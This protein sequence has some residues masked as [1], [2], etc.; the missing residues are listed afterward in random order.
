MTKLIDPVQNFVQSRKKI[1]DYFDCAGDYYI[2]PLVGQEWLI[3]KVDDFY[4]LTYWTNEDVKMDAVVVSKGGNP[5]IYTTKEY[6]MV[7]AIDCVKIAFIFQ[8]SYQRR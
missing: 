7:V 5:F 4:F 6:T 8:N 2:K 1:W 3:R